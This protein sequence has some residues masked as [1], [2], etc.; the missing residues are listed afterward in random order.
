MDS[1]FI[2]EIINSPEPI[3]IIKYFEYPIF[4]NDYAN[5]KYTILRIE[6]K[7]NNIIETDIPFNLVPF[8]IAKIGYFEEILRL[9]EGVVWER[10]SFRKKAKKVISRPALRYF[11]NQQ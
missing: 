9:N 1:N 2:K 4:L 8:V 6:K 3:A 5:A 10:G 11:I 7:H